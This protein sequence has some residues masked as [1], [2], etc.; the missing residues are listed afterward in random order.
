M[1]NTENYEEYFLDYCEGNISE[2]KRR[3]VLAFIALHPELKAELEDFAGSPV[4]IPE[5]IKMPQSGK[6]TLLHTSDYDDT[7]VPYF[8]RL[9]VLNLEKIAT[10]DEQTKYQEMINQN[11]DCRKIAELYSKTILKSEI[12]EYPDK[13]K[14]LVYPLWK[15]I[16]KYAAAASI[17]ALG[18]GIWFSTSNNSNLCI[19]P[20]TV[21]H[22]DCQKIR[23]ERPTEETA[24]TFTAN[25]NIVVATVKTTPKPQ[26]TAFTEPEEIK[27]A[28]EQPVVTET[29][30]LENNTEPLPDADYQFYFD[31]IDTKALVE[32]NINKSNEFEEIWK[33]DGMPDQKRKS[34]TFVYKCGRFFKKVTRKLVPNIYFDINHDSEGQIYRIAM[35]TDEKIYAWER[36]KKL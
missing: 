15:K 20:V 12:I 17:A 11:Q 16:T 2:E 6:K 4:L 8:E 29:V 9:A 32:E 1:I 19:N 28:E 30:N 27:P 18:L 24:K 10:K 7:D 26:E 31:E 3:E 33:Q 22:V 14:L 21:S 34:E 5:D 13:R 35:H 23:T 36:R 25:N